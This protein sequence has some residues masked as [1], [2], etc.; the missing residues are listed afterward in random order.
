MANRNQNEP[1]I[2]STALVQSCARMMSAAW[3]TREITETSTA[4]PK[5]ISGIAY[6]LRHTIASDF[7][8]GFELAVKA[9]IWNLPSPPTVR[10]PKDHDLKRVWSLVPGRARIEID[11]AVE[12]HMRSQYG[13]ELRGMVLPFAKYLRKHNGLLNETVRNRYALRHDKETQRS[14]ELLIAWRA[15]G[16]WVTVLDAYEDRSWADGVGTLTSYW[17]VIVRKVLDTQWPEACPDREEALALAVRAANQLVGHRYPTNPQTPF[18][19]S[20]SNRS[21]GASRSG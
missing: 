3:L 9:L 20:L 8:M 5:D 4:P 18:G 19:N 12:R 7:G 10:I 13:P 17:Y 6:A 16:T 14:M 11:A 1:M 2:G 15:L 21:L